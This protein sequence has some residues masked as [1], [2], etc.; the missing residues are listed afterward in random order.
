MLFKRYLKLGLNIKLDNNLATH[1]SS[2]S[3]SWT[4]AGSGAKCVSSTNFKVAKGDTPAAVLTLR[5]TD[6]LTRSERPC[7][8]TGV[9]TPPGLCNHHLTSYEPLSELGPLSKTFVHTPLRL[10][11]STALSQQCLFKILKIF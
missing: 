6:A 5:R 8:A 10:E 3:S 1:T 11:E 9:E 7:A 2:S 4:S